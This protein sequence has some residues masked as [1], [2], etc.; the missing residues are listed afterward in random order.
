[1]K[2]ETQ[3]MGAYEDTIITTGG[4][5]AGREAL[6]VRDDGHFILYQEH[7][8]LV[9][10]ELALKF[11][12]ALRYLI[13][14]GVK[15]EAVEAKHGNI[16]MHRGMS[17]VLHLGSDGRILVYGQPLDPDPTMFIQAIND[18]ADAT[19]KPDNGGPGPGEYTDTPGHAG[20]KVQ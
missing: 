18:F 8:Y 19:L 4:L 1:M 15:S 20:M 16:K 11:N 2:L 9:D 10:R 12:K 5:G 6:R 17:E 3:L 13:K 14:N 7:V